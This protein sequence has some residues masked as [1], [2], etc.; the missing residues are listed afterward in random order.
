MRS[1]A[2][3]LTYALLF[4]PY[5]LWAANNEKENIPSTPESP[6]PLIHP[7]KNLTD[8]KDSSKKIWM[9]NIEQT[10]PG[11]LCDNKKYF[12]T[13]FD[14]TQQECA[15][16]SKLLVHACLKNV[17]IGLPEVLDKNKGEYW[18]Q[19]IGKCSYDLYEK[20]M[21]PKKRNLA[22]CQEKQKNKDDLPKPSQATP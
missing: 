1:K 20:T 16:F 9:Q 11:L 19:V 4:L 17:E 22:S 18:G 13:C 12:V 2:A 3:L 14:V 15:D 6:T 21:K 10:L 8:N 7:N 5:L